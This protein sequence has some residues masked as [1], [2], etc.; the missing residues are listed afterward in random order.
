MEQLQDV[1]V[2]VDNVKGQVFSIEDEYR[3][4]SHLETTLHELRLEANRHKQLKSALENVHNVLGV[5]ELAQKARNFIDAPDKPQLLHAHKCLLELEK[6]RNDILAELDI[7][8]S[9]STLQDIHVS[10]FPQKFAKS[11]VKQVLLVARRRV[12]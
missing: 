8:H 12:L 9:E 3:T 2:S 5:N 11:K 1:N 6:C 7:Q 10:H 4:I